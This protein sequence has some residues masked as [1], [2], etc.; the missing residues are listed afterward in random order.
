VFFD[1]FSK[2]VKKLSSIIN[3]KKRMMGIQ[4]FDTVHGIESDFSPE[5]YPG[6]KDQ[7]EEEIITQINY[8]VEVI[9]KSFSGMSRDEKEQ[10]IGQLLDIIINSSSLQDL[11]NQLCQKCNKG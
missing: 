1:V 8:I 2:D 7:Y 6:T 4:D 3:L 5:K 9:V 10:N 11:R